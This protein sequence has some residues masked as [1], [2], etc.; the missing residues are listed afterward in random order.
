MPV[1]VKL[2]QAD[3]LI[4]A[5]VQRAGE[6]AVIAADFTLLSVLLM[7]TCATGSH[8]C[9]SFNLLI[10]RCLTCTWK[11]ETGD[12]T[13]VIFVLLRASVWTPAAWNNSRV[14]RSAVSEQLISN[15]YSLQMTCIY[16]VNTRLMILLSVCKVTEQEGWSLN[17]RRP[18]AASDNTSFASNSQIRDRQQIYN[19]LNDC[20]AAGLFSI[21]SSLFLVFLPLTC[22]LHK[23]A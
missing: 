6:V 9:C 10:K 18:A 22:S 19:L 3:G 15:E 16:I 13:F 17:S 21:C 23:A 5:H 11:S 1:I 7:G 14:S 12:I 20:L 8:H 2:L 4:T